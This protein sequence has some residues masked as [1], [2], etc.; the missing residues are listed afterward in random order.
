MRGKTETMESRPA[1]PYSVNAASSDVPQESTTAAEPSK[2]P[3]NMAA[4]GEAQKKR[5][6]R[7][8]RALRSF[9][10]RTVLL[11][12]V[13]YILLFHVVGLTVMPR[14][15]M[16]PRLDA[17]DMLLFYR[18]DRVPK[19]QDIIVIDKAVNQDLSAISSAADKDTGIVRR[20]LN[21]LG[22]K[23]PDAPPTQRFV[24]RVIAVPGDTVEITEER[25][26]TVNGN[27]LIE[28]YIY[29]PTKPYEGY[30]MYPVALEEGEY[31]VL[32]DL[33][34]GGVDSRY[35]GP[36]KQEEIQGIVITLLRRNNL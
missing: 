16:T 9:L 27:A 21:W 12:L 29:S 30:T 2:N 32:S 10:L 1:G 8:L 15:D 7:R 17:G 19:A 22:F 25:G 33:R 6:Y 31:F 36:V 26:L 13:V 11:A 24:C 14:D 28:P 18:I 3:D 5:R 23:D 4:A 34:N 35:F 20:A